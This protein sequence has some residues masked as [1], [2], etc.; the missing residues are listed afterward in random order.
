MNELATGGIPA[1]L[2]RKPEDVKARNTM[3]K[4]DFMR[5][6]MVQ[7]QHQDPMN[8][9]D[10][11]EF[12][13]QLAQF[14]SLEQLTN[15]GTG[16]E[17]LNTGLGGESKLQALGMMGKWIKATGE[18]LHLQDGQPVE[19]RFDAVGTATPNK[20]SIFDNAGKLVRELVVDPA[21]HSKS[22]VWDGMG[23]DGQPQPDGNYQFKIAATDKS[24]NARMIE[25]NIQGEV[26]SVDMDEKNPMIVIQTEKGQTKLPID[27][28]R[29][30]GMKPTAQAP[31]AVPQGKEVPP[32]SRPPVA[33]SPV[34]SLGVPDLE[35]SG[36]E[37]SEPGANWHADPFIAAGPYGRSNP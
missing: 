23:I 31:S 28:V 6:L 3:G 5:L 33:G 27:K 8:P 13:A 36:E 2:L 15:I 26:I 37:S 20:V 17:K 22:I 21:K 9:M 4:D 29:N 35:A 32:N 16:I 12:S 24:G 25:P 11:R 1:H 30:I 14:G 18:E 19:V 7:L 34:I 10:H